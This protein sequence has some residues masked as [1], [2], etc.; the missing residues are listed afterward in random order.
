MYK[1]YEAVVR[2][3]NQ[4]NET[5]SMCCKSK[6][7]ASELVVSVYENY[8]KTKL[9]NEYKVIGVYQKSKERVF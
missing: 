8:K 1:N 7:E 2:V 4:Q 3:N 5:L 6:K 9:I